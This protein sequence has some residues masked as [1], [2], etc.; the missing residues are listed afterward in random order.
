[1]DLGTPDLYLIRTAAKE[2]WSSKELVH[3]VKPIGNSFDSTKLLLLIMYS[4]EIAA[5]HPQSAI[6]YPV[7]I[8]GEFALDLIRHLH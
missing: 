6:P 2:E 8:L 7:G 4:Q 1:M 5:G 3:N